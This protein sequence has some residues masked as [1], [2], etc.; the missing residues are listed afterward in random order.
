MTVFS[1]Y[2]SAMIKRYR[3]LLT[4]ILLSS[5]PDAHHLSDYGINNPPEHTYRIESMRPSFVLGVFAKQPPKQ[6]CPNKV[7]M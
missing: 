7:W 3:L 5:I 4:G 6:C 2:Y 1:A